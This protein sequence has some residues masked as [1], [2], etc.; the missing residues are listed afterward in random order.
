VSNFIT[1][2]NFSSIVFTPSNFSLVFSVIRD[3]LTQWAE[4][5]LYTK[6]AERC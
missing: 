3:T 1:P 2:S 6:R 4:F 5:G